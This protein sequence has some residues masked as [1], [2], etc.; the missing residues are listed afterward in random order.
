[1][2]VGELNRKK[3][4]WL[5]G[6]TMKRGVKKQ[7]HNKR[8]LRQLQMPSHGGGKQRRCR[9]LGLPVIHLEANTLRSPTFFHQRNSL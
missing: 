5:R 3:K 1:M 9:Y 4:W 6:G 8:I 2:V 7:T